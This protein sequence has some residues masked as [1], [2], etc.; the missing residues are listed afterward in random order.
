MCIYA[1]HTFSAVS[2]CAA[3]KELD[4]IFHL[5][6]SYLHVIYLRRC[7]TIACSLTLTGVLWLIEILHGLGQLGCGFMQ[8]IMQ[9]KFTTDTES[10]E[11]HSHVSLFLTQSASMSPKLVSSTLGKIVASKAVCRLYWHSV[12]ALMV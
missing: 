1:S 11:C 9:S 5:S 8:D 12:C 6:A 4:I 2:C 10:V 3:Q 7:V